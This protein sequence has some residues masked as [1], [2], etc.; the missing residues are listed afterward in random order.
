MEKRLYIG[1]PV[2][3]T[4]RVHSTP[5]DGSSGGEDDVET[6]VQGTLDRFARLTGARQPE[7]ERAPTVE[8]H[9]TTESAT[10]KVGRTP[11]PTQHSIDAFTVDDL[12]S[13]PELESRAPRA[14]AAL[15][16]EREVERV[17]R[18]VA[19]AGVSRDELVIAVA[20]E[21]N[22]PLDDLMIVDG[23]I[24]DL[25]LEGKLRLVDE[26]VLLAPAP[27]GTP[28]GERAANERAQPPQGA[29]GRTTKGRG[30]K[31]Q[32]RKAKGRP[33][34]GRRGRGTRDRGVDGG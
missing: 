2:H 24:S 23:Y 21:C 17:A 6:T 16:L 13:G 11:A 15:A 22:V 9:D 14:M 19:K 31:P 27:R 3:T 30:G 33:K 4:G 7:R 32:G 29:R 18:R 34:R 26:R 28:A 1:R 12:P 10:T 5:G 25:V 20:R 8:H